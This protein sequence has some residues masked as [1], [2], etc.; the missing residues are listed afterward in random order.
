MG[1]IKDTTIPDYDRNSHFPECPL[2]NGCDCPWMGS[3]EDC[4]CICEIIDAVA[5]RIEKE[6]PE[7]DSFD[8]WLDEGIQ[9]GWVSLPFCSTHDTGYLREWENAEFSEGDD[10][11]VL[12]LRVWKDGMEE[13]TP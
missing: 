11:C 4:G 5:E 2:R 9:R 10:P 1:K 12:T 13:W 3:C 7:P 8:A 6:K